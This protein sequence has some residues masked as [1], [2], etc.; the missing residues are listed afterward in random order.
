[1]IHTHKYAAAAT[2]L[3][4]ALGG[5]PAALVHAEDGTDASVT[6]VS[7]VSAKV[8]D[9][10]VEASASAGVNATTSERDREQQRE[11]LEM[12]EA[13]FASSTEDEDRG[14]A[15]ST[16]AR[17]RNL[18][19]FAERFGFELEATT[20][21][22][23]SLDD[24]KQSIEER[25][26]ELEDEEASTTPELKEVVKNANEVRLAVHAL[27]ASK[28]LLGGIGPQVSEIAKRMNDS[29][30]TTSEAEAQIELRG[31]I[32]RILFGGDKK[33]AE[34]IKEQVSANQVEIAKLAE[35][36][37]KANV[38]ADVKA[39][40]E[41]QVTALQAAQDRLQNLADTESK[42]WGLLS[43]LF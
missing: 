41:A 40:L 4:L 6:S 34:A 33:S 5:A 11:V 39:T 13:K 2:A 19:R 38:S 21:A 29:V 9:D 14:N 36:L 23:E 31:F 8:S 15:T 28:D 37:A 18:E 3:V 22:A 20:T 7:V 30:A 24:L 35:A 17:E 26:Q 43:W 12:R 42:K 25:K 10:G 32:A 1:M 27:L 16:A